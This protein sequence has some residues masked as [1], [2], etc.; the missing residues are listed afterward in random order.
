MYFSVSIFVFSVDFIIK[1]KF[2][3]AFIE[4]QDPKKKKEIKILFLQLIIVK[5]FLLCIQ[6][7]L[8][9]GK[10]TEQ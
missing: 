5:H 1:T 4:R 9:E 3:N 6:Y 7:P 8:L 10:E 2:M